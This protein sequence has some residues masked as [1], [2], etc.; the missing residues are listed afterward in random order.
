MKHLLLALKQSLKS[1]LF[2]LR[3]ILVSNQ[4]KII[5]KLDHI[6][7]LSKNTREFSND[8]FVIVKHALTQANNHF[9]EIS[10]RLN[11]MMNKIHELEEKHNFHIQ[12]TTEIE[13]YLQNQP[14]SPPK[15]QPKKDSDERIKQKIRRFDQPTLSQISKTAKPETVGIVKQQKT[16]L[17]L[18]EIS[19]ESMSKSS[20]LASLSGSAHDE[21]DNVSSSEIA[22]TL[23]S[24]TD[25]E[26]GS[27]E[28]K[29]SS[30]SETFDS[31]RS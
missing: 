24:K 18:K 13:K 21:V 17:N 27:V 22:S 3:D 28:P 5:D 4:T 11:Q 6:I 9:N 30:V 19:K 15:S 12:K 25:N 7:S 14:P 31:E 8:E 10:Q 1:L 29:T 16:K 23:T 2:N 26:F 20:S